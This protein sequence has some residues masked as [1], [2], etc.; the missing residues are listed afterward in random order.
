M[1][2]AKALLLA[3]R[4]HQW[5]KNGFILAPLV[6]AQKVF[7]ARELIESVQAVIAFCA[8]SSAV[9]IFNDLVD[10]EADRNHPV[11]R[12]RPL[13]SGAVSPRLA[14]AAGVILVVGAMLWGWGL[15]YHVFIIMGIY[16][17]IQILYNVRLKE[18]V[19]LD[20]FCV[21]S[22]FFLRVMAGANAIDV[23]MSRW[24]IICTIL[25]AMFL[26]LCKRRNE[27]MILG[28]DKAGSHRKVLDEYDVHLLD[29]LIGIIAGSTLLSY[30]LY[31]LSEET[32]A[33]FQSDRLI[34]TF[35]FVLYGVFRYLYLIHHKREGGSP[36]KLFF[37]DRPLFLSVV[38][39]GLVSTMITAGVF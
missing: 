21:S 17:V 5:V 19:I 13:A 6:F 23:P 22:G 8:L 33:K 28:K 29:Q 11:K 30:L 24:L 10:L 9:Y 39:W 32:M 20:I 18:V 12:K 34:Y 38:L 7:S 31:C 26:T 36:E 35:P 14:S 27:L 1:T 37:S 4:P 2:T 16:L 25:I 15:G 3:F